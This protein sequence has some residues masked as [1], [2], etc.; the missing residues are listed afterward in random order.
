[1]A[2]PYFAGDGAEL[3]GAAAGTASA[4]AAFRARLVRVVD[5]DT[6]R[7]RVGGREKRVRLLRI[8]TPERGEAGY[9]EAT[10]ALAR[11]LGDGTLT[12]EPE[13]AGEL[14]RDDYG[15]LLAYVITQ[16]G[17][18]ANV[19]IVRLGYSRFFTRY[20]EGRLADRVEAAELEARRRS[21]G[22]WTARGFAPR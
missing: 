10:R 5:G 6:I 9:R 14:E 21:A 22:L 12:L 17:Q 7:V 11:I 18:N 16:D 2:K 13:R 15:R 8:D 4:G 3:D 19:E 20:G 1:M